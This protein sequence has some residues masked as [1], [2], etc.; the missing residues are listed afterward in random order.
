MPQRVRAP[1]GV[2][3]NRAQQRTRK[4]IIVAPYMRWAMVDLSLA[5]A[6]FYVRNNRP[7]I[8]PPMEMSARSEQNGLHT[9][10]ASSLCECKSA[11]SKRT[12]PLG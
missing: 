6:A 12:A 8:L 9:L 10:R 5:A 11:K 3:V 1:A 4:L 7:F 2:S